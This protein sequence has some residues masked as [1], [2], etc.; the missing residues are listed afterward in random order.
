[1]TKAIKTLGYDSYYQIYDD[2]SN[3]RHNIFEDSANL[4]EGISSSAMHASGIGMFA[5]LGLGAPTAAYSG[6]LEYM[7]YD[8]MSWGFG[9]DDSSLENMG[10]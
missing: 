4:V 5:A 3:G 7:Y 2:H 10:D 6:M 1:M 8:T 9:V